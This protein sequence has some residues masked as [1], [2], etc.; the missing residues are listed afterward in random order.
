MLATLIGSLGDFDLAEEAAQEAFALAAEK[1]PRDGIPREPVAWLVTTARHRAIDR[2]RRERMRADKYRVLSATQEAA[3]MDGIDL[4]DG[5]IP[6]ERLELIFTCCHPALATEAQVALTLRSLG[7]LTTAEIARS[8]L[9]SEETMKRR[10]TRAKKKI[11]VAAIPFA[12]PPGPALP[13]R[14]SAV[15][16]VLYLIFTEGYT[17]RHELADEA[18]RLATLLVELMPD[19]AEARGLLALLLLTDSRR[20]ARIAGGELV[21]LKEQDRRLHDHAKI[22]RGRAELDR[23]VALRGPAGPYTLQAAIASLQAE[24]TVDHVQVAR[25]YGALEEI[26]DSPV[27]TLNRAVAIAEGGGVDDALALVDSLGL[28][29]YRYWHSTRAELLRRLGRA[30]E[31]RA[32]YTLA[33]RLAATEPERRLL[34]RRLAD[35]G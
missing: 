23:A 4:D 34:A 14:L 15:L 33:V 22:D 11:R 5:A 10:I 32:A 27:V 7:G 21:P 25:L 12:V 8:F 17:E 26:T 28:D 19:E 3:Q 29:D 13:E 31:A 2:L 1:W 20:H 6:D 24:E 30:D 16:A 35:L 18:I 9:V